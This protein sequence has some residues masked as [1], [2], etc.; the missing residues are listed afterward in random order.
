L[1]LID[2]ILRGEHLA[3]GFNYALGGRAELSV[4]TG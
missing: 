1:F 2:H 4:T 3:R